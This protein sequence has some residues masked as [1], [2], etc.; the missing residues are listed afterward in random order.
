VGFLRQLF[1]SDFMPHGQCLLWQPGVL[2]LHVVSDC[3][4]AAAYY[5]IPI[6]LFFLVRKHLTAGLRWLVLMFGGVILACGATHAIAVWNIWHAAYGVEGIVKAITAVLSV[7]TAIV[8]VRITPAALRLT[9]PA[10]HERIHRAL[11]QE[12]DGRAVAE[13][14]LRR[15]I[16]SQRLASE[17]K[18][19][20]YFEAAPQA[21]L[22][23]ASNGTIEL[24]NRRAEEMF[25]YTRA[26]MVGQL[27]KILIPLAKRDIHAVHRVEFFHD[28]AVRPMEA[29][30]GLTA[31]HKDGTEFPVEIGLSYI[32]TESGVLA[33][34]LVS[35]V[36]ERKRAES[37]LL[38]KTM[39]LRTSEA[40]L[41]SYLEAASQA[42]LAVSAQGRIVLVNRSTEEMFG[43]G[44]DELLGRELELLLPH[45][46]QSVHSAHRAGFFSEPRRRPMGRGTALWGRRKNGAEFPVEV[47][48]S[49]VETGEG[50]LALGL[51]SDVTERKRAADELAAAVGDL[52]RSNAELEQFAYVAS[53]D[54]QEPLRMITSY[55]N[56]LER[57]SRGKLDADGEEFLRYA[58]D[59]AERMKRLIRDFLQFSR[60]S[61]QALT[62]DPSPAAQMVTNALSNLTAAIDESRARVLVGELPVIPAD[63]GLLTQVFQNLIGNAIKFRGK[64]APEIQIS[65][66]C[67]NTEW[68]FS[69]RDNGIG[70]DPKHL[71]RIFQIFE[72]LHEVSEYSGSGIGLAISKKVVERHG[73]RI[74]VESAP[75]SG[76]TFH[77]AIPSK[78]EKVHEASAG[79]SFAQFS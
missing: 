79:N 77:F 19:G 24:V 12:I 53:H 36:T 54:L 27:L 3:L 11:Q 60:I 64:R 59:G 39:E 48:L 9:P 30:Q 70:I 34:A 22:I 74:W 71:S 67:D 57:R 62:L 46:Y 55:L 16:E 7:A 31:L 5:S 76:S 50:K 61:R 20:A 8:T 65:A 2:W 15:L 13:E 41:R 42:I 43:Y 51:I 68:V 40:Q 52:R 69:V 28:P 21:I 17:A 6:A 38:R 66:R 72:R 23:V 26:E 1:S 32:E 37:E 73:G 49:F 4:I 29:R 33:M 25:G 45:R 14:Q 44:R 78:T 47:G 75:G 56:L 58:V 10:E 35:D 18:I 63:P